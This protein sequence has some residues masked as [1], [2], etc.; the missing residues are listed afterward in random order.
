MRRCK[1]RFVGA[2]NDVMQF[3]TPS[4]SRE[5]VEHEQTLYKR[6]PFIGELS[7]SCEDAVY[8]CKVGEVSVA[9]T[10]A[11]RACK[12][13]REILHRIGSVLRNRSFKQPGDED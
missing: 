8:R 7:C 13:V 5:G 12:H 9:R 4:T 11:A 3:A 1:P 10:D 2:D 6:G